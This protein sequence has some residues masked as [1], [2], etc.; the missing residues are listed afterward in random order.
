MPSSTGA[1]SSAGSEQQWWRPDVPRTLAQE[2][3]PHGAP[4]LPTRGDPRAHPA[5]PGRPA[6]DWPLPTT[7][8]TT[9]KSGPTPPLAQHGLRHALSWADAESVVDTAGDCQRRPQPSQPAA[10]WPTAAPHYLTPVGQRTR[11]RTDTGR[12]HRTPTP[13]RSDTRTGHRTRGQARV[14]TGRSPWTLDTERWPRT[15]TG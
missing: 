2:G 15:R 11:E 13:G 5:Y 14:D 6:L 9:A 12:P 4:R 8:T 3:E 7:S 1:R 10:A